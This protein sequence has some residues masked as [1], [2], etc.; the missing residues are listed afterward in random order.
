MNCDSQH[1]VGMKSTP[2]IEEGGKDAVGKKEWAEV[3]RS[4]M[5]H[6]SPLSQRHKVDQKW[7]TPD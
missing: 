5:A 1:C 3:Q 7:T 6:S 2:R 4:G